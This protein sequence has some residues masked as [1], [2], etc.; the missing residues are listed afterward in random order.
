MSKDNIVAVYIRSLAFKCAA[1]SRREQVL[2]QLK[3][4]DEA[5]KVNTGLIG[6]MCLV[7]GFCAGLALTQMGLI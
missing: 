4:R 2:L 1:G 3:K 7:I 5:V 6:T